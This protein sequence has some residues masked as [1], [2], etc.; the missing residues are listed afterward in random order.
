MLGALDEDP[1]LILSQ[2]YSASHAEM[3]ASVF[4]SISPGLQDMLTAA[5]APGVEIYAPTYGLSVEW[6][7]QTVVRDFSFCST[8]S[9]DGYWLKGASFCK[10][11]YMMG[12]DSAHH[13]ES[14]AKGSKS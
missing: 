2:H 5:G 4:F 10:R 11:V 6:E 1:D 9:E 8:V 13:V 3:L 12:K 14:D 7:R